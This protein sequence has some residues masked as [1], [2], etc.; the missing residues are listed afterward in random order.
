MK[1]TYLASLALLVASLQPALS[2]S[3]TITTGGDPAA[4]TAYITFDQDIVFTIGVDIYANPSNIGFA[5]DGAIQPNDGSMT[6]LAGL[7]LSYQISTESFTRNVGYWRDNQ[8]MTSENI[9]P[10]DSMLYD[11]DGSTPFPDLRR[12]DTI[13][14]F[15]GTFSVTQGSS[16]FTMLSSGQYDMYI[17]V[18]NGARVSD[19]G[20]SVSPVPV[21]AAFWL[22]GSGLVGLIGFARRK[23]I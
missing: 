17:A 16:A 3:A 2:Q 22:F 9:S 19:F 18:S 6:D 13:R 12:G 20:A 4:G 5:I 15:A 10:D 7:G 8:A 14:L 1:T 21:P 11:I 23:Q